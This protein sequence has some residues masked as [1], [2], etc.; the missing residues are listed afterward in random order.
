[1]RLKNVGL[2]FREKYK[3]V[4]GQH[5][6]GQILDLP[7]TSRVSNFFSARRYLRVMINSPVEAGDVII[8]DNQKYIVA[9]HGTGF[10]CSPIYKHFKLFAVDLEKIL[11]T[12]SESINPITG[13]S[14]KSIATNSGIIYIS[15]QPKSS[16]NDSSISI[17]IPQHTIIINMEVSVDDV[18]GDNWLVTRVDHQLGIYVAEVKEG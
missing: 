14:E 1:M 18:I 11:Y 2:R 7:D 12:K 8:V 5:F 13:V 9:E 15:V 6:Y 3:I 4:G 10:F 16:I 17:Q